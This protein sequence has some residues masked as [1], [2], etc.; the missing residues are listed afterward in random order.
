MK[1]QVGTER[2][3]K[4]VGM[5][6]VLAQFE[7]RFLPPPEIP[8]ILKDVRRAEGDDRRKSQSQRQAHHNRQQREQTG[9]EE[10]VAEQSLQGGFGV[11]EGGQA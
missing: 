7:E 11:I 6:G 10:L 1:D 3:E 9:R 2:K 5:V 4:P 8:V